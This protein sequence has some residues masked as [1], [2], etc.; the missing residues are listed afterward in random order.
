MN[1]STGQGLVLPFQQVRFE[2]PWKIALQNVTDDIK[3]DFGGI[4]KIE[5]LNNVLDLAKSRQHEFLKK[6]WSYKKHNDKVAYFHDNYAKIVAG[7]Q[8]FKEIGDVV[9]QYDPAHAALPWAAVRFF[10]QITISRHEIDE[11]MLEGMAAVSDL[12]AHYRMIESRYLQTQTVTE[13]RE[14]LNNALTKL[15]ASILTFLGRACRYYKQDKVERLTK[16]IFSGAPA[17]IDELFKRMSLQQDDIGR[18]LDL[19]ERDDSVANHEDQRGDASEMKAS[20][21]E[22]KNKHHALLDVAADFRESFAHA[23]HNVQ[24]AE[25]VRW[26]DN[27][28]Y[29]KHHEAA[30]RGRLPDSGAWLRDRPDYKD[31]WECKTPAIFWLTGTLGMGK[32]AIISSFIDTLLITLAAQPLAPLLAYFYISKNPSETFR[33]DASTIFRCLVQQLGVS[34]ASS[35]NDSVWNK[36]EG[37]K[38]AYGE[39]RKMTT[40]DCVEIITSMT[41]TLPLYLIIDALDEMP[42]E[43]LNE[44]LRGL[45]SIARNARREVKIFVSSRNDLNTTSQLKDARNYHFSINASD[46]RNDIERFVRQ[47]VEMRISDGALLG[48]SSPDTLKDEVTTVLLERAQGM[49]RW[50]TMQMNS[51]FD[52]N[53]R[54]LSVE[55]VRDELRKP[56]RDL[57]AEYASAIERINQA[58]NTRRLIATRVLMWLSCSQQLLLAGELLA[59]VA[60]DKNGVQVPLESITWEEVVG[61]CYSMVSF[62]IGQKVFRFAH[63]SVPDF[64]N[65]RE[66][67]LG[68]L[69]HA[70]VAR[71]C[72][73]ILINRHK[74]PKGRD[75][76]AEEQ[77]GLLRYAKVFWP[78]HYMQVQQQDRTIDLKDRLK[79][80]L[81]R[82]HEGSRFFKDWLQDVQSEAEVLKISDSA[83]RRLLWSDSATASP[84][85]LAAIFNIP[86][87][88]AHMKKC[89]PRFNFQQRNSQG[90]SALDLAIEYGHVDVV[91]FLL[92][93]GV[94][95]N[96]FNVEATT[97]FE[98][99]ILTG[100]LPE[101]LQFINPLQAAAASEGSAIVDLL[102]EYGARNVIGGCFGD[103]LQA[104]SLKGNLKTV[105]RLLLHAAEF[106]NSG[107]EPNSQCGFHGNALQAAAANG[108][109]QIITLL[110]DEGAE[111]NSRGGYYGH[112]LIA[113]LQQKHEEA[114]VILLRS[115][116]DPNAT[117]KR[118]GSA[119]QLACSSDS[120]R[121]L[122]I[123]LEKGASLSGLKDENPY[124]LHHAAR[125]DLVYLTDFLLRRG[126]DIEKIDGTPGE[127]H[128][129]PLMIAAQCRSEDVLQLL[130]DN[131]ADLTATGDEGETCLHLAARGLDVNILER[132]LQKASELPE[133]QLKALINKTKHTD[134]WTALREAVEFMRIR[135]VKLL[136][137]AGAT[138][139]PDRGNETPLHNVAYHHYPLVLDLLLSCGPRV[140]LDSALNRRNDRGKTPLILA[141]QA[142]NVRIVQSLVEHGGSLFLEDEN[143]MSPLHIAAEQ[144]NIEMVKMFLSM[145]DEQMKF[146]RCSTLSRRQDGSTALQ[147]AVRKGS[148]GVVEL[149]VEQE[150]DGKP[151]SDGWTVLHEAAGAGHTQITDI[152]LNAMETETHLT[153]LD[154]NARIKIRNG[155]RSGLTA[156]NLAAKSGHL[157]IVKLLLSH[158][159]N[160]DGDDWS[161]NPIHH[162]AEG[163]HT[164]VLKAL[165][166][167]PEGLAFINAPNYWKSTALHTV[168]LNRSLAT[169]N[170][171]LH[172]GADLTRIDDKEETCLHT[173]VD[174]EESAMTIL[175]HAKERSDL[176]DFLELRNNDTKTALHRAADCGNLQV[177]RQLVLLGADYKTRTSWQSTPLHC[178]SWSN[179]PHVASFLLGTAKAANELE[180][181]ID[182]RKAGQQSAL[183]EAAER[184]STE[185]AKILL[186]YGADLTLLGDRDES[187]LHFS[188]WRNHQGIVE[189]LLQATSKRSPGSL[190][191]LLEYQ[192]AGSRTAFLDMGI[193]GY[194]GII[195]LLL[196][197]G[198]NWAARGRNDNKTFLMYAAENGCQSAVDM[199]IEFIIRKGVSKRKILEWIRAREH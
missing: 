161:N 80:L 7:L 123:V 137:N 172:L 150:C 71:R 133:E 48:P 63:A 8:R 13:S 70:E 68:S 167:T 193:K 174:N 101:V 154:I 84:L 56:A 98:D 125:N 83:K 139:V 74:L 107:F 25:L 108:H 151:N 77:N 130:L 186:D 179:H 196:N 169:L 37:S 31:W 19:V 20:L 106:P 147:L 184:G 86:E 127:S 5:A 122:E 54:F 199:V 118:Y 183:I 99:T 49:F 197:N 64:L 129:T 180:S 96:S 145:S 60:V 110:I 119:V 9:V 153:N 85:F 165:L 187:A 142:G 105:E 97:Q 2:N 157:E 16:S 52:P 89:L 100:E 73:E 181:F 91:K 88:L 44:L 79:S 35:I 182:L 164:E 170:L 40:N 178:A 23:Q 24:A 58:T 194:L 104:A 90:R 168:V 177:V 17:A 191:Q 109:D 112:A 126:Y 192:T 188:A 166:D 53:K 66:E 128:S 143:G 134:G 15:Y 43:Q 135:S 117:S 158:K 141:A 34:S 94:E 120:E 185:V 29:Y 190:T 171:L 47:E 93:A 6:K 4:E 38:E 26:L 28:P 14:A 32:S 55:D 138:L 95:I 114:V 103:A 78:T 50:V 51:L 124:L 39:A 30:S 12:T 159:S 76:S 92:E 136:V 152:L 27:V 3:K 57:D 18:R 195:Q 69:R 46:N 62:D 148:L 33:A 61:M 163:G 176:A 87:A 131:G 72:F 41:D 140:D 155:V 156:L 175:R 198:V 162:A 102:L 146:S 160:F 149:L 116:V 75:G 189:G 82:G 22:L 115:G 45:K 111:V 144:G 36:Y 113:A 173:A 42:I 1:N 65:T 21:E 10:L 81:F 121:I 132:L 67:Y 11:A 59:A